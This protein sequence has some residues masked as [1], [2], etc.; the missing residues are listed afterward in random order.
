MTAGCNVLP[1][2]RHGQKHD[3]LPKHLVLVQPERQEHTVGDHAGQNLQSTRRRAS[4]I[5]GM[6]G[7]GSWTPH[8]WHDRPAKESGNLGV[9]GKFVGGE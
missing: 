9:L 7:Y 6:T 3:S 2:G 4:K 1:A 8:G 5:G